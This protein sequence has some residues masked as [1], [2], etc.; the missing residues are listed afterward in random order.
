MLLLVLLLVLGLGLRLLLLLRLLLPPPPLLLPLPVAWPSAHLGPHM[1]SV[2]DDSFE[3]EARWPEP[4][5]PR[6]GTTARYV[7]YASLWHPDLGEPELP[8]ERRWEKQ[9]GGGR[10]KKGGRGKARKKSEL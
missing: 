5:A 10:R 2:Q 3:H 1:L 8:A 4:I 7:L 9:K 6:H